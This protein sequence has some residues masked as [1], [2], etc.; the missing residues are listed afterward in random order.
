MDMHKI[1]R[2]IQEVCNQLKGKYPVISI[3]GPRQSGKRHSVKRTS[4]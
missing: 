4:I 1:K 3:T 2:N